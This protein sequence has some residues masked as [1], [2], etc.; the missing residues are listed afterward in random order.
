M[1][2]YDIII[3]VFSQCEGNGINGVWGRSSV[4]FMRNLATQA[5]LLVQQKHYDSANG[6]RSATDFMSGIIVIL[7]QL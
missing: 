5:S 4:V 3:L 6:S 1:H 2:F 7:L